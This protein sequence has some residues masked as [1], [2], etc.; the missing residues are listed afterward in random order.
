V[1]DYLWGQPAE[2]IVPAQL[3]RRADRSRSLDWIHI[4]SVAGST[5]ALHSEL[6]RA[7]NLRLL[8]RGQGSITTAGI[9]AELPSLINELATGTLTVNFSWVIRHG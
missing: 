2:R 8:G 3:T 1:I 6:L 9:I 7:A 4:G 5:V